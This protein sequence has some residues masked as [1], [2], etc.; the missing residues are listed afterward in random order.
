MLRFLAVLIDDVNSNGAVGRSYA[1]APEVDGVIRI[2][3]LKAQQGEIVQAVI[4]ESDDHDLIAEPLA[5]QVNTKRPRFGQ[6]LR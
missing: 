4:V 5:L 1:E 2:P 3:G 6:R